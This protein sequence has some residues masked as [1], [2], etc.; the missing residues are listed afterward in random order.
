[1]SGEDKHT[2][3]F[4][5]AI[6][7]NLCCKQATYLLLKKE[8]IK[9]LSFKEEISLRFH[10]SICKFC[11][12]FRKQSAIINQMIHETVLTNKAQLLQKDKEKIKLL[13]NSNLN[14]N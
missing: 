10:L 14:G 1:M 8:E 9:K 2:H 7:W 4:A 12:L 6:G 5:G 3:Y 13:I 11:K